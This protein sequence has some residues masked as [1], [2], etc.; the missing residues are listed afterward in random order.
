LAEAVRRLVESSAAMH[1]GHSQRRV[2][3]AADTL[4]SQ[5]ADL[6]SSPAALSSGARR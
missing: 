1:D 3:N 4:E 5:S 2:R 6:N